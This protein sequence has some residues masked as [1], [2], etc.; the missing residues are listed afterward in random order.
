MPA[1]PH[2]APINGETNQEGLKALGQ[3]ARDHRRDDHR[4]G[5]QSDAEN[6]RCRKDGDREQHDEQEIDGSSGDAIS[7]CHFWVESGEQQRPTDYVQRAKHDERDQHD[8][9]DVTLRDAENIAEERSFDIAREAAVRRNDRD[10]QGKARSRDDAD[11]GVCADPA[12]VTDAVNQ[13]SGEDGPQTTTEEEIDVPNITE[14][15]AAKDGMGQAVADVAHAAQDD[16]DTDEAAERADDHGRDK[17][18][19]EKLVFKRG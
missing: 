18:V 5:N 4:G 6:L 2:N 13:D 3:I 7:A 8:D 14:H 10:A 19:T 17:A 15:R 11:G 1:A 12:T 9:P 16:V